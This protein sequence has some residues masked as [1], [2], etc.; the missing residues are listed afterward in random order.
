MP[1]QA[2][3]WCPVQLGIIL[4]RWTFKYKCITSLSDCVCWGICSAAIYRVLLR[5][6]MV[7]LD[8]VW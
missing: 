4:A 7:Q 8:C 1:D 3:E 2:L 5:L 6:I